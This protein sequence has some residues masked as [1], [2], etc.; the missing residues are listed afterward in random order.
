MRGVNV[1][2][3]VPA[4]F[5]GIGISMQIAI[6]LS[7]LLVALVVIALELLSVD[8]V[9]LSAVLLLIITGC[10]G[11]E[12]AFTSFGT[13]M[14][15]LLA[16]IF[17]IA[18]ALLKTGVL[19]SVG[20]FLYRHCGG[21]YRVLLASTV[22]VVAAVSAFMNNTVVTA[23]FTPVMLAVA[24]RSD[25]PPSKLL[26]PVAF[27]AML[28]GCCTLVGTST[29]IAASN[30]LL[31]RGMQPFSLFE[32]LPVGLALVVSGALFFAFFGRTLLPA[33][34]RGDLTR[35]YHV[36][37]YLT[38]VALRQGCAFVGRRLG[39]VGVEEMADVTVL[40]IHRDKKVHLAPG[41]DD[42]LQA[43]DVLL[44]KGQVE[45][46][47]KLRKTEGVEA[48]GEVDLQD[49]NLV[50]ES[51]KLVEVMVG[52]VSRFLGRT[53]KEID[54][55]RRYG[56]TAL[57]IHR[58]GGEVVQKVGKIP[59]AV[60]DILLV[61]GPDARL[62][63]LRTTGN[64]IILSDLSHFL[65]EKKKGAY[66][67]TFFALAILVTAAGIFPPG[68]SVLAAALLTVLVG[69]LRSEEAYRLVDWRL[70]VLI[71]GMTAFGQAMV[72]TGTDR[73][74]AGLVIDAAGHFGPRGL[75][76]G[77]YLLTVALTQPLSNAA[78]ALTVLPIALAT[79]ERTGAD[80]RA[81]AVVVTL[82][83]SASF[84]T[85][86]EPSC[87]IVYPAGRYRFADFLRVG[88]PLTLLTMLVV[89]TMVPVFWKL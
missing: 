71:G 88:V 79:A 19:D 49:A 80:P 86:L 48:K 39:E 37:E 50:S 24:R 35:D 64:V 26:M 36:K 58:Q 21:N 85:P 25:M 28:G 11:A 40:G 23:V 8:V 2:A 33:R 56:L 15:V 31:R 78:A 18:G 54:F 13:D 70:L 76:M 3:A 41:G 73:F 4:G 1:G 43:D 22:L 30:F 42:V 60:G 16:S 67:V 62:N 87:I 38:E 12:Q 20:V 10:I 81:F 44:L 61:Q 14:M 46:I 74:L 32:F 55:R 45:G 6:V 82:A 83:A 9:A 77:F 69:A 53:L 65:L 52:P 47:Q 51:V 7:L 72:N 63:D 27:A 34:G 84:M 59:L 89:L 66:V 5:A 68:P 57:A 17:I 29:N 75:L